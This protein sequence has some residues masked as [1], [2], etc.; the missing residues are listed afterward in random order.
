MPN[1][2]LICRECGREFIFSESE[3]RFYAERGFR[4]P[5]RCPECRRRNRVQ[6]GMPPGPESPANQTAGSNLAALPPNYLSRGYY[7]DYGLLRREIFS[8]E[9]QEVALALT[10]PQLGASRMKSSSLRRFFNRLKAL[11]YEY[12]VHRN[13][14]AIVPKLYTFANAA[15]YAASRGVV[16][17]LFKHFVDANIRLAT[18]SPEEFKGFLEHY[19]SVVAYA[20]NDQGASPV[21]WLNLPG[22]PAGYLAQGYFDS[23]GH[24]LRSVL[25]EWPKE[26]VQTFARANPPL[27]SSALRNFFTKLKAL[28]NR[29]Q[30]S[31]DMAQVLPDLYAFE[32]DAAYAA[33][34]QVVPPVFFTFIVK[35]IDLATANPRNFAGFKEHFQAVVAYG[36]GVL[37]EGGSRL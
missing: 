33:N 34:R 18:K 11:E 12:S 4:P 10:S 16:P 2:T 23:A 14:Q 15:E 8:Q 13:F 20:R 19:Q 22:L 25:V 21:E 35:N 1:Q 24:L 17:R 5:S 31:H 6:Q 9:A 28:E 36:K 32:R 37:R 27:S 3:Q 30:A 26:L 29:L 7:D